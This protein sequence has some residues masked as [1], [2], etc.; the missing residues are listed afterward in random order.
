MNLNWP[1]N[2]LLNYL[3]WTFQKQGGRRPQAEGGFAEE[4][5]TLISLRPSARDQATEHATAWGS[6]LDYAPREHFV[7]RSSPSGQTKTRAVQSHED[8]GQAEGK[9]ISF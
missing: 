8:C 7:F 6:T 1:A 4:S 9:T 3:A 2:F 5:S